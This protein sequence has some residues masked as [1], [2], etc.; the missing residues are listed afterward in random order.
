M[1]FIIPSNK[2]IR[3][4]NGGRTKVDIINFIEEHRQSEK[5]INS[6]DETASFRDEL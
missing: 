1:Y 2:E 3:K 6:A 5:I 4:Y